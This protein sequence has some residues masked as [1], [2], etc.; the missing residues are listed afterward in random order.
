MGK[1]QNLAG[2]VPVHPADKYSLAGRLERYCRGRMAI[3]PIRL[4]YE[5]V[6]AALV[7][8]F[9]SPLYG[10]YAL[11]ACLAG[12]VIETAIVL[13]AWKGGGILRNPVRASR[14]LTLSSL[15]W[16]LAMSV[17][18]ELI[19]AAGGQPM[20][21]LAITFLWAASVNAQLVGG[22]HLPS[23]YMKQAVLALAGLVMV[24]GE[25][26]LGGGFSQDL[27]TF[28]LCS[29]I[30]SLTLAGLFVRLH[31][32]NTRRHKA[33]RELLDSTQRL[34]EANNALRQSKADLVD[35]VARVRRLAEEAQA[36]N[37]AKSNFL[38]AMS[39]EIRTPMNG[40]L[41]MAELLEESELTQDQ[42]DLVATISRSGRALLAI[43]NDILDLSKVEAGKLVLSHTVFSPRDLL[44]DV[45][46]LIAPMAAAKG[47]AFDRDED[48]PDG[49]VLG[50]DEGRLRQVLINLLGN[51]VKFTE[52]G[53]VALEVAS[54][55]DAG[56]VCLEISVADTGPGIEMADQ[57][58]V[59]NAFEQ[60][61][62]KLTRKHGGTGLGLAISSRIVSLMGGGI[63]LRSAPGEGSRFELRVTLPK[64]DMAHPDTGAHGGRHARS[65]C[66]GAFAGRTILV[67][68]DNRTNAKLVE[69]FLAPTGAKLVMAEDGIQALLAYKRHLP[70]AV[71]MDVSMPEMSG[72]EATRVIRK[73]EESHGLTT[74]PILALTANAF[75]ED[76][77]RCLEAGMNRFLSKPIRKAELLAALSHFLCEE[78]EPA[79]VDVSP[80]EGDD[81]QKETPA[82][83][84]AESA[85]TEAECP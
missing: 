38:A 50:G 25:L 45:V 29:A 78:E 24:V 16:A 10:V 74:R 39:H 12:E 34:E 62:G 57:A 73:H 26:R 20:W 37:M 13:W 17:G 48:L 36:A 15:A 21:F 80:T 23:L 27:L 47:L 75:A 40:V 22:L 70:D 46:A 8:F 51:A 72:I 85:G 11:L 68:E 55:E 81:S 1:G 31:L 4:G 58:R 59:F 9:S 2:P 14:V 76:R 66:P 67:A 63:T 35:Q 53:H 32:Q 65:V 54:R 71:L 79:S 5:A 42:R 69:R 3:L 83:G 43:I 6:G 77:D 18:V 52:K 7:L 28:V 44:N 41:G 30:M 61:D 33:E 49:L 84:M 60:V 56:G 64:A 82:R 19:W